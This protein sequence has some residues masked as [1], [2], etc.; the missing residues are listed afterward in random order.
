MCVCEIEKDSEEKL[1]FYSVQ[2]GLCD[3]VTFEQRCQGR[4]AAIHVAMCRRTLQAV[5]T[6]YTMFRSR[7]KR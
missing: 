2:G 7:I 4:E 1:T 6:A 3:N 5:E